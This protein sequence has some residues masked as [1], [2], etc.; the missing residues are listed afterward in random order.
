[1]TICFDRLVVRIRLNPWLRISEQLPQ[2]IVR[3]GGLFVA[4][5]ANCHRGCNDEPVQG[6]CPRF[7]VM[8]RNA[9]DLIGDGQA[10][11]SPRTMT[12]SAVW[13]LWRIR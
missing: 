7:G 6:S 9:F 12:T 11:V 13:A 5:K 10:R 3:L 4:E 8:E 2:F 1:M